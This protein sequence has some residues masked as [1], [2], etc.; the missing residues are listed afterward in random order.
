MKKVLIVLRILPKSV[1]IDLDELKKEI[2][3][4]ISPEKVEKEPIAFG[5]VGLRVSKLIEDKEGEVQKIET[6]LKKLSSVSQVD[7][8]KVTRTL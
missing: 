8:I 3:N 4:L 1:E 6:M 5:L 7:V 2:I